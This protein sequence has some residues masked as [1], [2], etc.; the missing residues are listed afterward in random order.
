MTGWSRRLRTVFLKEIRDHA[1]D[2]RSL[3]LALIYPLLGPLLVAAGLYMAGNT[4]SGDYKQRPLSIPVVGVENAPALAEHLRDNNIE[5]VG[6]PGDPEIR[7]A[8]VREGRLPVV[9]VIPSDAK[10]SEN[11]TV[12]FIT[13][14][15]RA[16]NLRATVRLTDVIS[17]YNAKLAGARAMAAGLPKDY[18]APIKMKKT[19]VARDANIAVFFYNMIPPLIIFM[20]FLGGVHL[21][22]DSTVGERERGALE[23]LLLAPVER[24]V[25]LLAKSGAALAFTFVTTLVNVSAFK[26]FLSLAAGSSAALVQPPDWGV[27]VVIIA[28]AMP[29]MAIAVALQMAIA[30]IT[31]SMKE[32]QIYLGLLPLV[33]ALPGMVMVFQPINPSDI[34]VALPV[35]GQMVLISQLISEQALDPR[36]MVIA[37]CST[38]IAAGLIFLLAARWFRREKMFVLG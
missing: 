32:A 36:H 9:L 6:A 7:K 22:I 23:P 35:F 18:A 15:G 11:F 12:E 26:G 28:I 25:L 19:N 17:S 20:I 10:T 21:A 34:L 3:T 27:F 13:N 37:T 5:I 16:D 31:K 38:L 2:R 14:L 29:L 8:F 1:R 4:L 30:V 24:W 33:P